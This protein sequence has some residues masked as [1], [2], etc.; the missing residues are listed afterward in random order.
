MSGIWAHVGASPCTSGLSSIP[1]RGR[2]ETFARLFESPAGAVC[3]QQ[4]DHA[5]RDGGGRWSRRYAIVFDGRLYKRDEPSTSEAPDAEVLLAAFER[6]GTRCFDRLDGAFAFVIW[7]D[8]EKRLYAVRDRFGLRPLYAY[9]GRAGLAFASE[10]KQFFSLPGVRPRLHAGR[11]LDFLISGLT[12]HSTETLFENVYRLPAGTMLELN[13]AAWKLGD[14]LPAFK[15]WYRLPEPGSLDMGEAEAADRFR[16]LLT[17]AV[18]ARWE[19]PGPR[20]LC[21]SGGLDSAA[22]AGIL[23]AGGRRSGDGPGIVTF[24]ARFGDEEFDETPLLESVIALTGVASR[25]TLCTFADALRFIEPLTWHLDEPFSRASLAAQ[26]MLFEQAAREGVRATLDG[27][28]S[29][30]QLCGYTSMVREHLSNSEGDSGPAHAPPSS[31]SSLGG[32]GTA[33]AWDDLLWLSDEQRRAARG[34]GAAA[35][36]DAGRRSLGVICRDRMLHGDLPMMMRHNDRI[37]AAH[38]IETHVPFLAHRVVEFSI[39]L[40]DKYKF[41]GQQTKY[42]LRRSM[43]GLVPAQVLE[44]RGKGSYSKLEEGWLRT[45]GDETWLEVVSATAREWPEIFSEEGVRALTRGRAGAHKETLLL[46]WRI[47]CFGTWARKFNVSQ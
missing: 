45:S 30:E 41:A 31:R 5:R 21:L 39:A 26:W 37:G 32:D 28:G 24:K 3:L 4:C 44:H 20:G 8:E 2:A 9:A 40:G 14:A 18:R 19:T 16:E 27:Q 10:I 38:G 47:L 15:V 13:L 25:Q 1:H 35:R 6:S 7:D 12:D 34:E 29:D 46:L 43:E 23:A 17:E 36:P 42:L 11:A 33:P 22:I